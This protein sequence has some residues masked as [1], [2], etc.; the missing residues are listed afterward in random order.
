MFTKIELVQNSYGVL[1]VWLHK[2]KYYMF[3]EDI[4]MHEKE[5]I[6]EDEDIKWLEIT[7]S[8]YDEL[9]KLNQ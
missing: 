7:Q 6:G 1:W 5:T 8:L 4:W 2:D 9:I 3:M